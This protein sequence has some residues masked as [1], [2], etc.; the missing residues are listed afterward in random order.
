MIEVQVN[1]IEA[2]SGKR[3]GIGN[4]A[5]IN[6]RTSD[7]GKVGKYD[8]ITTCYLDKDLA[9][10]EGKKPDGP[11]IRSRVGTVENWPRKERDV[12]ELIHAAIGA[13]LVERVDD[14][15]GA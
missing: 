6:V 11:V 12:L 3:R 9:A 7:D 2:G 14:R 10:K 4:I 15:G 8:V 5:I 1:L 13:T